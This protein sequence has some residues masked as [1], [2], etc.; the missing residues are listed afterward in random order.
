MPGAGRADGKKGL[1]VFRKLV[2]REELCQ[3]LSS[4]EEARPHG[5]ATWLVRDAAP[6]SIIQSYHGPLSEFLALLCEQIH[7]L[8][9]VTG[10]LCEK[11]DL[12]PQQVK[13]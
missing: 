6:Q 2:S 12:V 3:G 11:R 5:E 7:W 13:R 10:Q 4:G 1:E 8:F 9:P